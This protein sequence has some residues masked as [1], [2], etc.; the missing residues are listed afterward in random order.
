MNSISNCS[1]RNHCS[2]KRTISLGCAGLWWF[3]TSKF[4]LTC[5]FF[6]V[7]FTSCFTEW[8]VNCYLSIFHTFPH[9]EDEYK[10]AKTELD[11]IR[12][13]SNLS[14]IFRNICYDS[15]QLYEIHPSPSLQQDVTHLL[16]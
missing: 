13:S 16:I 4:F 14:S 5:D 12:N 10:I 2:I 1:D 7:I 3:I 15:P 9:A 6:L 11:K 8:F